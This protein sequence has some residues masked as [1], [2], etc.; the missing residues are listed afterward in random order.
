MSEMQTRPAKSE[1]EELQAWGT[2]RGLEQ[3]EGSVV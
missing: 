1:S 3:T 2:V